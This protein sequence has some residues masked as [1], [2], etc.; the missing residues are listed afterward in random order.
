MIHSRITILF[1]DDFI[2]D[3]AEQNS[4]HFSDGVGHSA[5]SSSVI[6]CQVRVC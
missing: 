2:S 5:G 3:V 1:H 6:G 4:T